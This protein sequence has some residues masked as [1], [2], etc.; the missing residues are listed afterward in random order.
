MGGPVWVLSHL[1]SGSEFHVFLPLDAEDG[2]PVGAVLPDNV[3]IVIA[4]GNSL[5]Q[6]NLP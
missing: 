4:S 6:R 5:R 3:S 1:G 2:K